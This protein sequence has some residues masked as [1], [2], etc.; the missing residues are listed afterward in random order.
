MKGDIAL[1]TFAGGPGNGDHFI[2]G[3]ESTKAYEVLAVSA[4]LTTDATVGNR[5]LAL[6][7]TGNSLL[8]ANDVSAGTQAA[9]LTQTWTMIQ[10][11]PVAPVLLNNTLTDDLARLVVPKSGKLN[12]LVVGG[13][14]A[15]ALTG[16]RALLMEL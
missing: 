15:D 16:A 4:A 3:I 9:S 12:L 11:G 8:V 6:Q 5:S 10:N 2:T 7:V 14:A 13:A 1:A